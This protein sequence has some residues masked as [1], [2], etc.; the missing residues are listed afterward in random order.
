[1]R[2][3][4]LLSRL[5]ELDP[6][7]DLD[8]PPTV[9][10]G[11]IIARAEAAAPRTGRWPASARS[12]PVRPAF[13]RRGIALAAAAVIVAGAVTAGLLYP[14]DRAR[15]PIEVGPVVVPIAHELAGDAPPAAARLRD[16]ARHLTSSAY[17]RD[18]GRYA[19]RHG[20][21]WG[22]TRLT[23]AEGHEMSFV[24]EEE[25]WTAPDGSGR[26]RQRTVAAE[27]PDEASRRYWEG[28][29]AGG[30]FPPIPNESV[31]DDPPASTSSS[32]SPSPASDP[33]VPVPLTDRTLPPSR[34]AELAERLRAQYGAFDA[35]KWTMELYRAYVVPRET[36]RQ[37]IE[38]LATL[39]G[40]VWRGRVTDRAG[41][42]GVAISVDR[43]TGDERYQMVLVFDPNT[44]ELLAL[45]Y[46]ELAPHRET[47]AY[48]I[49]LPPGRVDT[50][51][52]TPQR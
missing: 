18:T 11:Q 24:E 40:F 52:A 20:K 4:N 8:V 41:R 33:G 37:V 30:R 50:L 31:L 23:S 49:I 45:D 28:E 3:Q 38:I 42:S 19:Y 43:R 1:V 6:A 10:A 15:F 13:R 12:A 17:D 7:R 9:P 39:D 47:M 51:G 29:V 32:P 34:R 2:A 27:F 22:A 14:A 44:G 5:R 26:H 48:V 35:A 16:L 21:S 46:V 25:S 36:R